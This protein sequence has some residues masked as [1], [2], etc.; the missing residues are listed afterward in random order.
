MAVLQAAVV[1]Y[2]VAEERR[3]RL[4]DD[5]MQHRR[6]VQIQE[7]GVHLQEK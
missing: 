5:P 7:V 6:K 1:P 4:E 2:E 3:R